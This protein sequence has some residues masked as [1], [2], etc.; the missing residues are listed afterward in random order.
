MILRR[1]LRPILLEKCLLGGDNYTTGSQCARVFDD[2]LRASRH[3]SKWPHVEFLQEYQKIGDQIFEPG[4]FEQTSYYRNALE[5]LRILAHYFDAVRPEEIQWGARRFATA[6]KGRESA[7]PP[8]AGERASDEPIIVRPVKYSDCYQVVS[9]HHR[10]SLAYVLGLRTAP[11]LIMGPEVTTPLQDILLDCLWLQGRQELAQPVDLP[12]VKNW[13]LTRRC[14]D[15]LEKMV[16]CLQAE[17]IT[18]GSYLDI[19]SS[20]GWFVAKM[21]AAGFEAYGVE[22]DPIAASL[23][24]LIYGLH[25][26]QSQVADCSEFLRAERQ[27]D[28]TSCF[29]LIHQYVM[30]RMNVTAEELIRLVDSATRRVLFCDMGQ[31]HEA[32]YRGLHLS[33]WDADRI[34]SWLRKNTTFRRILRLGADE[35]VVEP[36]RDSFGQMLFACLR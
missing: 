23:G 9:G 19:A 17:G 34:E 26:G 20:Y 11:A 2:V 31:S 15:R 28:V 5:N 33:D 36:Y 35:D 30:N 13:V 7:L 10:L 21:N 16:S 4:V 12:E 29:S 18:S 32:V 1:R 24:P 6:L 27:Y 22:R 25:P 8:P 14:S 3:I